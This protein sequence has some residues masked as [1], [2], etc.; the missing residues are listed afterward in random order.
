[1]RFVRGQSLKEALESYPRG[2]SRSPGRDPAERTLALRQL[3]GRFIDVCHAIA[4][5]HSRG[6]I[7]RDL[8]PANILLGPYGETLVVD[9]GLAKVVGRDDPTPQPAAEMTLRPASPSGSSETMAGTAIGT[10]LFMSPEQAE[11]RLS[12][13]G[14]ASDIYCLGATL[15]CLLT[16]RPAI[17]ELDVDE[18]LARVRSGR[19]SRAAGRESA[20]AGCPRGDRLEGDGAATAGSIRIGPGPGRGSRA[21]AGRRAGDRVARTAPRTSAPAVD[22]A[23]ANDGGGDRRDR[24]GVDC[25]GS[26]PFCSSRPGPT[27][28]SSRPISSWPW[29]MQRT[30]NA[31]R[32]LAARQHAESERAS[33]FHW[34]R[35]RPST[36]GSAKTCCSRR[37]SSTACGP[38]SCGA[39]PTSTSGWKALLAGEAD[40]HSRAAARAGLSRHRRADSPDRIAGRGA[41]HAQARPR[42]AAGPGGRAERRRRD[43]AEGGREPDR[44]RRPAR[45]DRRICRGAGVLTSRR[46]R[47]ARAPGPD[48]A[49]QATATARP[50]RSACTASPGPV[51]HGPSGRGARVARAGADNQ[52]E[53]CR[54]QP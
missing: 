10:P 4:Y 18:I 13:I 21:L 14:P 41:C 33:S 17:E 40:H 11:G 49:R 25:S 50:W 16:G 31:N 5:A 42:A 7:H 27:P 39:R 45:G 35:S 3:L 12:Q 24:A 26:L 54:R 2:R 46:T 19:L 34:K 20:R 37:N 22:R 36:A 48:R 6:V 53:P 47:S 23:A 15:Y 30:G 52:P 38:S 51:Q 44:G 8:K 43:Q 32:E 1:M 29:P 9:W 28:R